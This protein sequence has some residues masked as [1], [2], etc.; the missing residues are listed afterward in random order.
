MSC[1]KGVPVLTMDKLCDPKL[2]CSVCGAARKA[3]NTPSRK[4]GGD[5]PSG[6][7]ADAGPG[8]ARASSR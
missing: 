7:V 2:N 8:S 6:T 3:R 4:A 5:S 1:V